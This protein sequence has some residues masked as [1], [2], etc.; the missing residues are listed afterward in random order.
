MALINISCNVTSIFLCYTDGLTGFVKEKNKKIKF[1]ESDCL[2]E[3]I[4][5]LFR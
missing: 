4:L 5:L 2:L 3:N 1:M